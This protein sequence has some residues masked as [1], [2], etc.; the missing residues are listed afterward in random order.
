[1]EKPPSLAQKLFP[2]VN[3]SWIKNKFSPIKSHWV[4]IPHLRVGLTS[5]SR[6]STQKELNGIF[7]IS[8][9]TLLYCSLF[10]TFPVFC[11]YIM[12]YNFVCYGMCVYLCVWM[13][14]SHAS[15]LLVFSLF[16]FIWVFYCLVCFLERRHEVG[17]VGKWDNIEGDEGNKTMFII[18]CIKMYFQYIKQILLW[19]KLS[20]NQINTII[21]VKEKH[22]DRW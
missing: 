20:K 22:N 8:Y 14:V 13:Y 11:W 15:F 12:V 2:I 6:G 18:N 17:R 9:L 16:W 10:F 5:N 3:Q 1:M 4:Y 21:N 7:E 19:E